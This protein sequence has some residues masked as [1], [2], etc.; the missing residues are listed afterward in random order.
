MWFNE[1]ERTRKMSSM[2]VTSR[3]FERGKNS[4]E[5][6]RECRRWLLTTEYH[7]T[8]EERTRVHDRGPENAR[9]GFRSRETL[10]KKARAREIRRENA[11]DG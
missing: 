2:D 7:E 3:Q 9:E 6:K 8:Y 5:R 10:G 4:R 1:E 11:K